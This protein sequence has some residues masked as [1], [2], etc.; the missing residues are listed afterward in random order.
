M[1]QPAPGLGAAGPVAP[2][3]RL[4]IVLG[5]LPWAL[6]V[7]AQWRV[8]PAAPALLSAL[9][10]VLAAV[11]CGAIAFARSRTYARAIADHLLAGTGAAS[12]VAWLLIVATSF[13]HAAR[14]ARP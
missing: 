11:P 6:L 4:A 3:A 8:L 2:L 7:L 5:L 1:A 10:A 9:A 14:T 13:V 12:G